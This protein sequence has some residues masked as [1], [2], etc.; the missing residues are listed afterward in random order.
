MESFKEVLIK[1]INEWEECSVC[2]HMIRE[3]YCDSNG[4][5]RCKDCASEEPNND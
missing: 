5:M 3:P 4:N 1:W 2:N